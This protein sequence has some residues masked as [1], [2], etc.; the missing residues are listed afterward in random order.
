MGSQEKYSPII[1]NH[2]IKDGS[3]IIIGKKPEEEPFDRT[4]YAKELSTIFAN[5]AQAISIAHR[6]N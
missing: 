5:F 4:E 3:V 6:P 1:G 2:K